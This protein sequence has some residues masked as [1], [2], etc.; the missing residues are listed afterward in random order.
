MIERKEYLEQLFSWKD[1]DVIKVITG[2]RRSGKSTLLNC[3]SKKLD[4][5]RKN[6]FA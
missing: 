6:I 2:I 1:E 3:I 4:L 5:P